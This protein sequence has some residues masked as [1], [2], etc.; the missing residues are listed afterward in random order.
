[1]E[2]EKVSEKFLEKNI[3]LIDGDINGAKF[4]YVKNAFANLYARGSPDITIVI[5][6]NGGDVLPGL[7]V[8]DIL[9]LYPGKK[10]GLVLSGAR[11]MAA[12]ILQ[13][14]DVRKACDHADIM[15]HHIS[16]KEVT[17]DILR[18]SKRTDQMREEME[19]SQAKLYDIL[20]NKTKK[21]IEDI[22]KECEKEKFMNPKEAI[23][24]GLLDEI[25]EGP[26][27]K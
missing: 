4:L 2:N 24:F 23:A 3:L 8:F 27:P 17:L 18:D 21:S 19:K 16:R 5:S 1:M 15:I 10:T 13:A 14:C 20:A 12:V 26:L 22:R 6:S 11:S 25:W 9:K 7:D